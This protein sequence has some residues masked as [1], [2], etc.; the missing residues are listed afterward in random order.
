M[1]KRDPAEVMPGQMEKLMEVA[2]DTLQDPNGAGSDLES[3]DDYQ[4]QSSGHDDPFV[5]ISGTIDLPHL[6]REIITKWEEVRL[7]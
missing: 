2:I 3:F 5:E 4:Y 7:P 6:I 1:W